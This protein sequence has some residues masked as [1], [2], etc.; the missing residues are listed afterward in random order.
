MIKKPFFWEVFFLG[1]FFF[2][3]KCQM[4][5]VSRTERPAGADNVQ[6]PVSQ[7]GQQGN[8][9]KKR[10][11]L[12]EALA[13]NDKIQT[14]VEDAQNN[15]KIYEEKYSQISSELDQFYK[16][17]GLLHGKVDEIF[18]GLHRF[19]DKKRKKEKERLKAED[20]GGISSDQEIKLDIMEEEIKA[21][22]RDIDQLSLD[23][24]SIQELDKS[25]NERLKKLDEQIKK[26][27]E[28]AEIASKKSEDI[29]FVIDDKKARTI[30]FDLKGT[31]LPTI[32][33]I[34]DYIK[35]PLLSN[36]ESVLQTTR[37]KIAEIKSS[38]TSLEEKGLII[39]NRVERVEKI[40]LEELE[41]SKKEKEASEQKIKEQEKTKE[42]KKIPVGWPEK[43]YN[44][45]IDII[46]KIILFFKKLFGYI[47]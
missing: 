31:I 29:W 44:F 2:S 6:L 30:F 18:E 41:K 27:I 46:A 21:Q 33:A 4:P 5:E 19:V 45:F 26:I 14:S 43:I 1:G 11:W 3:V 38:I 13:L 9:V 34:Q 37:N 15:K 22:E 20:K 40:K 8:W 39:R 10:T 36:F 24:K 35:G 28:Q 12:K 7:I 32:K 17:E 23:M 42:E 16:E 25:I 47:K